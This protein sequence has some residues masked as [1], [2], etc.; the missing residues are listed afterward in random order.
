MCV[1]VCV[2][3]CVCMFVY[4]CVIKCYYVIA[5]IFLL[6]DQY[7]QLCSA[8]TTIFNCMYIFSK[9]V[10]FCTNNHSIAL[11]RKDKLSGN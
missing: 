10:V 5:I 3:V 6:L 8:C 11:S 1:C 7:K 4:V 2:C 9:C